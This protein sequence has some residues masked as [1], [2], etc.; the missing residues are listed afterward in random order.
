[1]SLNSM[2]MLLALPTNARLLGKLPDLG[3]L[4][5]SSL[6]VTHSLELT[7]VEQLMGLNSMGRLPTLPTNARL[8][9]KLPDLG[10]LEC[11]SLTVAFP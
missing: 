5:C 11:L 8:L 7:K 4:E 10:K 3:K 1:M 9:G 6:I 2:G